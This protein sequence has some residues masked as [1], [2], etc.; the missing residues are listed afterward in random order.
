MVVVLV[1]SRLL[2]A[3]QRAARRPGAPCSAG[4][5]GEMQGGPRQIA[6]G[7]GF[8]A[9]PT[10]P[11]GAA[12][13]A[14]STPKCWRLPRASPCPCGNLKPQPGT[15]QGSGSGV[16]CCRGAA[17]PFHLRP[18]HCSNQTI[19]QP[20]GFALQRTGER[21]KPWEPSGGR[22]GSVSLSGRHRATQILGSHGAAQPAPSRLLVLHSPTR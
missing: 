20:R 19:A 5:Q 3:L 17:S 2:A 21:R 16:K 10:V 8:P 1:L 12:C 11:Q 6:Q 13:L 22:G 9:K 4:E 18:P 15:W 14:F 7:F